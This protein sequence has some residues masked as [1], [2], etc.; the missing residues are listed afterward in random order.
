MDIDEI[1]VKSAQLL[2]NRDLKI[3]FYVSRSRAI[4]LSPTCSFGLRFTIFILQ[5]VTD[6][7]IM[8]FLSSLY[9]LINSSFSCLSKSLLICW[10]TAFVITLCY[11]CL[12]IEVSDKL[13]V[14][15]TRILLMVR[16]F[17]KLKCLYVLACKFNKSSV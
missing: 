10:K 15:L 13:F 8:C 4:W 11:C 1:V 16:F 17:V 9:V 3:C 6:N 5:V 2:V 7:N 12:K 14:A